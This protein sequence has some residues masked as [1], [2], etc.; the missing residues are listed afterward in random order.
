M[1]TPAT[2]TTKPNSV[3]VNSYTLPSSSVRIQNNRNL[4]G[5]K[6]TAAPIIPASVVVTGRTTTMPDAPGMVTLPKPEFFTT[7]QN[8]AL[9]SAAI[10]TA[11]AFSL[12]ETIEADR[13][14]LRQQTLADL[15]GLTRD[16]K[17]VV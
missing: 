14:S 13:A 11:K 16:R 10:N 4:S 8:T 1:T 7:A 3:L 2:G 9:R 5:T 17:S 6:P 15:Y 12:N